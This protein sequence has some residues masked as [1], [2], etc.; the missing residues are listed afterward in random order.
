MKIKLPNIHVKYINFVLITIIIIFI[1]AVLYF[2]KNKSFT[3]AMTSSVEQTGAEISYPNDSTILYTYKNTGVISFANDT[4][5]Q[6]LL[7]GGGGGGGW[8]GGGGGGG[9]IEKTDAIIKQG[10]YNISVGI[11]SI[12]TNW[13][14]T[15]VKKGGDS[16]F[17]TL[18]IAKGGGGGGSERSIGGGGTNEQTSG[19][20][21][22]GSGA[23][24][25]GGY[26]GPGKGIPG[27]GYDGELG[28]DGRGGGGGGAGGPGTNGN[29]GIG[30]KSNITGTDVYYGG[31]GGAGAWDNKYN[32]GIGG[33]GGGGSGGGSNRLPNNGNP[34]TYY[35]GGGGGSGW[36]PGTGNKGGDGYKGIVI[37]KL[38]KPYILPPPPLPE[39]YTTDFN[40]YTIVDH[41][42]VIL[43]PQNRLSCISNDCKTDNKCMMIKMGKNM[44]ISFQTTLNKP[45][46]SN[47]WQQVLGITTDP[48]GTDK[49]IFGVFLGGDSKS[50]L[51][52]DTSINNGT[53]P[54]D[55][56][57]KN[58]KNLA[59]FQSTMGKNMRVDILCN[60]NQQKHEIYVNGNL[61]EK[62]SIIEGAFFSTGNAYVF[63]SFNEFLNADGNLHDVVVL[64]S[65]SRTFKI[66]DLTN[67]TTHIDTSL[68]N[69]SNE[70][71]M[72][73]EGFTGS[74]APLDDG[75]YSMKDIRSMESE[76]LQQLNGFNQGY[77]NYIK[78]LYNQRHNQTGDTATKFILTD[79]SGNAISDAEFSK[80]TQ[81]YAKINESDTYKNLVKDLQVFNEA[82]KY[83]APV[84]LSYNGTAP[85]IESM[86]KTRNELAN[87]RTNLDRQLTELNETEGTLYMQNYNDGRGQTFKVIL[88][89]TLATSLVYYTFMH[90]S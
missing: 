3:E 39:N 64:T 37:L 2:N 65:E 50:G 43:Q 75:S 61:V 23:L 35:G 28:Q 80:S 66:E 38:L 26:T 20:S 79:N 14:S 90:A 76:I 19:G 84:D 77:A 18:F 44:A 29:G 74:Y 46:S 22:A 17:G 83:N 86:E 73:P 11:G 16:S 67:A 30:Y 8:G 31:G 48:C 34:G 70:K 89:T 41:K 13:R 55:Y 58:I 53:T 25:G 54:T 42:P 47:N 15:D 69:T 82:L 27:Q 78:F 33:N 59:T 85:S 1:S 24:G 36:V 63:T 21:G 12:G 40:I 57:A 71:S 62:K 7:V 81:I 10:T 9:V 5:V 60:F 49:R 32:T 56:S 45:N 52:L 87:I 6:I 72:Q 51:Y 88:L 4:R 68:R